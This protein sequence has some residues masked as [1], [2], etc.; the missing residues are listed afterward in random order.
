MPKELL[1]CPNCGDRILKTDH[2]YNPYCVK[3]KLRREN[4]NVVKF[5]SVEFRL[6]C[7]SCK[8]TALHIILNSE[9]PHDFK[10]IKCAECEDLFFTEDAED[11]CQKN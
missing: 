2:C 7:R 6:Q 8:A 9:N 3:P 1:N 5:P 11:K 10:H 4:M